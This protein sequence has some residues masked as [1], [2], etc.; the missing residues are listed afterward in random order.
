MLSDDTFVIAEDPWRGKGDHM[1]YLSSAVDAYGRNPDGTEAI[2]TQLFEPRECDSA[3]WYE[4]RGAR[5][6]LKERMQGSRVFD[7]AKQARA[8]WCRPALCAP[9]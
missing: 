3:C 4:A 9:D 5:I 2:R 1:G 7:A 6:E 8:V